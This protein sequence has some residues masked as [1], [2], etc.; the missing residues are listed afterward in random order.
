MQ[1]TSN[2]VN[3]G[4]LALTVSPKVYA[5]LSSTPFVKPANPSPTPVIP[6]NTNGIDQT[7]IWYRFTLKTELYTLLHNMDKALKQQL[8]RVEEDIYVRALN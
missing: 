4:F 7:A 2:G 5:T 8:L 6:T 1:T 3:L